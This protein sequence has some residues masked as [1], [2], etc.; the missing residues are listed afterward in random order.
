MN[1]EDFQQAR[2]EMVVYHL[3]KRG[4]RDQRVIAAFRKVPRERFVP[5]QYRKNAY[6]D[7]PLPIGFDQTIS[8]PYIVAL[9]VEALSLKSKDRVLEIGTGSGYQTAILAEIVSFV[10]SVER[11]P[12]L[13]ESAGKRLMEL[14]YHNFKIN[15]ADGTQGWPEYAPFDAIIVS[16]AAAKP[17]ASLLK[18]LSPAGR[19]VIPIGDLWEQE[20]ILYRNTPSGTVSKSFGG[21]RFVPLVGKEGWTEN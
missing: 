17:P 21:C 9:M 13:A 10:Y 2:E 6:G 7:F 15:V 20:L 18:Q 4:I 14:G 8:Q 12:Q 11:L 3:I 16:A 5:S 1:A 19:M